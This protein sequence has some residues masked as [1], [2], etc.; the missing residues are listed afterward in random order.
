MTVTKAPVHMAVA[1][2]VVSLTM[3]VGLYFAFEKGLVRFNHPDRVEF[4]IYGIDVSHHQGP[5]DWPVVAA[6][7][8]S[9]VFIKATEGGDF[10]DLRFADNW[11]DANANSNANGLATSAYHFFTLCRPGGEQAAHFLQ[12]VT[13]ARAGLPPVVDLEYGGNCSARPDKADFMAELTAF[14]APVEAAAGRLAL[15][16]VTG[17][18]YEDYLVGRLA[19]N[20]L[21]VRN[22]FRRPQLPDERGWVFWQYTNRGRV[23]GISGPVDLNV[24]HGDAA[25]FATFSN[26]LI[27]P[28]GSNAT[29]LD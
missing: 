17:E 6:S 14:L 18:F 2:M 27:N 4:P 12:T 21:W 28:A 19:A 29:A 13:L 8:I 1:S 15:L 25:A 9:F 26:P 5:I 22:I 24:F 3:A 23:D 20:P 7:D 16:Y 10:T 11:H